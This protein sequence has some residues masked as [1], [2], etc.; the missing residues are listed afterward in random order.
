MLQVEG[1]TDFVF[2]IGY[3]SYRSGDRQD[4]VFNRGYVCYRHGDRE[5]LY[6]IKAMCVTV[7]GIGRFCF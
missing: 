1:S 6:L 3:V 7:V 4:F 2:N 5:T